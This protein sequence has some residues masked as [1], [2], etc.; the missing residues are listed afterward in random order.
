MQ[1]LEESTVTF[2]SRAT[3]THRKVASTVAE[4]AKEARSKRVNALLSLKKNTETAMAELKVSEKCLIHWRRLSL[5]CFARQG[6]NQRLH[7]KREKER[8]QES[9]EFDELL[10]EGENPYEVMDGVC[11]QW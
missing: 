7:K 3:E 10:A 11:C 5:V 1:C 6:Q 8:K 9:E 2:V 4:R